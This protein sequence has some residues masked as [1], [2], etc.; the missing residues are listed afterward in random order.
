MNE[1][2]ICWRLVV[3]LSVL[4]IPTLGTSQSTAELR[5][6]TY[7][8]RSGRGYGQADGRTTSER[9]RAIGQE[10]SKY[11]PDILVIQEPGGHPDLYD[12]LASAMG[13][14]YR[15]YPIK[16]ADYKEAKRVG[17]L[18]VNERVSVDSTNYCIEGNI[19]DVDNLFNHWGRIVLHFQDQS[20]IVYGF[21]L[22]PRQRYKTRRKQIDAL[23]PYLK[24]DLAQQ[25]LV[26]VAGDLNHRPFDVEYNRWM[27]L[28]LVDS[29]DSLKHGSGFTK[30]DELG[31]DVLVPYRRIDYLLLSKNLAK[32]LKGSSITLN[33]EVFVPNPDQRNW[34]LSDH[35]PVMATFLFDN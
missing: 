17:L 20:L 3:I 33:Q 6:V 5:I 18:I 34:S 27:E 11:Q 35:F 13:S 7:N 31:E 23:T 12:T 10:V 32:T 4:L 2:L 22:A 30:M 21:K 29:Y 25:K 19:S 28:G 15:F 16:C 9:F 8:L 26:I 1:R 14:S 24:K